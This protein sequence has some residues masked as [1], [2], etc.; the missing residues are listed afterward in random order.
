MAPPA[1][2]AVLS[3]KTGAAQA[4]RETGSGIIDNIRHAAIFRK[5]IY[6]FQRRYRV[7]LGLHNAA[8]PVALCRTVI[9]INKIMLR[10]SAHPLLR[11]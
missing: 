2:S 5:R 6:L 9:L 1:S 7:A 8:L 3:K 11:R 4:S 10:G